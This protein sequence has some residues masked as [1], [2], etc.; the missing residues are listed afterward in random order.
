MPP[1][2]A[3]EK[4]R[5]DPNIDLVILD[6]TMPRMDGREAFHHIRNLHPGLPVI[7]SSGFNEQD[8]IQGLLECGLAGFL[9][10]P[11]TL[12][13]LK[14]KIGEVLVGLARKP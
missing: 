3:V 12:Q 1:R 13:S 2:D 4:V 5:Q 6:L 14:D 9:Q 10:K 7:L 8:S 11:Y